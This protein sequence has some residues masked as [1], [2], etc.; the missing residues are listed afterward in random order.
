[1]Q[2]TQTQRFYRQVNNRMWIY[3]Y[4][5]LPLD[6]LRNHKWILNF[7]AFLVRDIT[8]DETTNEESDDIS[9]DSDVEILT[10]D[11]SQ[12]ISQIV[13]IRLRFWCSFV[14]DYKILVV[15]TLIPLVVACLLAYRLDLI[16]AMNHK[17]PIASKDCDF[18]TLKTKYPN[19]EEYLWR[20]LKLAYKSTKIDQ[21]A[22]P[23]VYLFA[24][25][26]ESVENLINDIVEVTG[27][28]MATES[29]PL[30]LS[31]TNFTDPNMET[32]YGVAIHKFQEPLKAS[33]VMLVTGLNKVNGF[34]MYLWISRP[35]TRL[36][37]PTIQISWK[38]AQAFHTICDTHTP[39]VERSIIF[40]TIRIE[41]KPITSTLIETVESKLRNDWIGLE[42][43]KLQPLVTRV[44]DFVQFLN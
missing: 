22:E 30:R 20:S 39:F 16:N 5:F 19:Q 26:D 32:D 21:K 3:V 36:A 6:N 14:C 27:V 4:V 28:C 31:H 18:E 42:E 15:C 8:F 1:M 25:S 11:E 2:G 29:D 44:T 33:Q 24:Y 35:N 23:F 9:E 17:E 41:S 43:N 38:V 12:D 10:P 37:F 13:K 7:Y 34:W 40:L